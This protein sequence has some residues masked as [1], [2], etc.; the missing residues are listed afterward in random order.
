MDEYSAAIQQAQS[1][2]TPLRSV[3]E[4]IDDV[5]SVARLEEVLLSL[6]VIAVDMRARTQKMN[7]RELLLHAKH[8]AVH[9]RRKVMDVLGSRLFQGLPWK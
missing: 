8:R 7:F 2:L 9:A 4:S 6:E 3:L 1:E 5:S